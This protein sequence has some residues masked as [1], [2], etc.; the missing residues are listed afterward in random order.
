MTVATLTCTYCGR[1][2]ESTPKDD[3]IPLACDSCRDRVGD[4]C[5]RRG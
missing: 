5:R 4:S 2:F 3:V 1:R